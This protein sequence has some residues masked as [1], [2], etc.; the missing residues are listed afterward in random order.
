MTL[1]THLFVHMQTMH[2]RLYVGF[3]VFSA[4]FVTYLLGSNLEDHRVNTQTEYISWKLSVAIFIWPPVKL[5]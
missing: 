1:Q 2:Y 5:V 4:E 3:E